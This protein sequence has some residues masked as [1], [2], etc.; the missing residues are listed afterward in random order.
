M[1]TISD[2]L[3][4][5]GCRD[6]LLADDFNTPQRKKALLKYLRELRYPRLMKA[7]TAFRRTLARLALPKEARIVA[8]PFFESPDYRLEVRF[9]EGNSLRAIL[10]RLMQIE[11]LE[12]LRDPWEKGK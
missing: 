6:I 9:R 5:Q 7:E 8:P 12:E 11:G 4:A 1:N 3:S 10:T 2:V